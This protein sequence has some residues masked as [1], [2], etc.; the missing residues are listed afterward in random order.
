M[1]GNEHQSDFSTGTRRFRW[2]PF[3]LG[4]LLLTAAGLKGYSLATQ[5][6]PPNAGILASRPFLIA[7]VEM[8]AAVGLWLLSGLRRQTARRVALGLF[9]AF[10]AVA[11]FKTLNGDAS[12]ACFGAAIEISPK[13]M[14]LVDILSILLLIAYAPEPHARAHRRCLG[15][16]LAACIALLIAA[17]VP[18]A[19]FQ[20]GDLDEDGECI[21]TGDLVLLEPEKWAGKRFPLLK[22][23][24][25]GDQLKTGEWTVILYRADCPH[26]QE[27]LPYWEARAQ[28]ESRLLLVE[29][30]S[31]GQLA[32]SPFSLLPDQRKKIPNRRLKDERN[33]FVKVPVEIDVVNGVVMTTRSK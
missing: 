13:M 32:S 1:L 8:E 28:T 27:M 26:C 33:W 5:P 30:P 4:G 25:R 17:A 9:G 15:P 31:R 21:G 14:L 19:G 7:V 22:Y 6:T 23:I 29:V 10:F 24:D 16:A 12:C 20:A 2:V 3:V 18:M 11:L